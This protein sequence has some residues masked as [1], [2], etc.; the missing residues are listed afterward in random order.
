MMREER[1][2][3]TGVDSDL[4]MLRSQLASFLH[5]ADWNDEEMADLLLAA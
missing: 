5:A 4:R 1:F 2:G 3:F